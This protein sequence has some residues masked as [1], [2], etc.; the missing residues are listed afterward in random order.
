MNK[1]IIN[2]INH[3]IINLHV[4][5]S[6]LNT[7]HPFKTIE[8]KV[9]ESYLIIYLLYICKLYSFFVTIRLDKHINEVRWAN[10]T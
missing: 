7:M 3:V 9:T 2:L 6:F 10:I 1:G 5:D 8:I 4:N